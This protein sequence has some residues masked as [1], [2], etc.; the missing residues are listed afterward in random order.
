MRPTHGIAPD[1]PRLSSLF[2]RG[3][4]PGHVKGKLLAN[5]VRR[6][7]MDSYYDPRDLAK[8]ADVGEEAPE[9]AKKFF[10]YYGAVFAEAAHRAGKGLIALAVA[11]AIQCPYCIDAIPPVWKRANLRKPALY[12]RHDRHQEELRLCLIQMRKITKKI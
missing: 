11:H 12:S 4:S 3:G 5:E 7:F 9:L 2:L 6:K 8:F 10:D 1:L